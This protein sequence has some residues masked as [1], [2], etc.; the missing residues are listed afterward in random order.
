MSRIVF[1][2]VSVIGCE[3]LSL[4]IAIVTFTIGTAINMLFSTT[5]LGFWLSSALIGFGYSPL[6]AAAYSSLGKYFHLN[7]RRTSCIFI[8]GM[9]GDAVHSLILGHIIDFN[10][11][12]Y[13]WY[14]GWLSICF[15]IS[16]LLLPVLYKF[17]F[18]SPRN[19]GELKPH[20]TRLASLSISSRRNTI[21]SL[22]TP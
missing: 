16:I 7:G 6:F 9:V 13:I 18:G 21:V 12:Y 5:E 15:I 4:V 20:S 3:N 22:T 11:N 19:L 1:V 2:L 10:P 8:I 17:L 14:L